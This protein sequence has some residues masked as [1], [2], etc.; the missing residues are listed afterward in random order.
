MQNAFAL[1]HRAFKLVRESYKSA[2]RKQEQDA[3][4]RL[5]VVDEERTAE[6]GQE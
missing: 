2:A 5:E 6:P 3:T 4:T 1:C